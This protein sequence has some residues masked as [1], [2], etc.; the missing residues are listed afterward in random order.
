M[1][2]NLFSRLQE[3]KTEAE[4]IWVITESFLNKLSP[5]LLS[6]AWAAVIP[7]WFNPE[8]LA[9]LRPELQS[10]IAEL[11]SELLNLPFIEVFPKRGYDI[12]EVTRKVMLE[13]LWREYQDEFYILSARAA[14]YFSNGDKP[15]IQI[16]WLYHL[17]VVDANS[18]HYELFNL[19]RFWTNNF[20]HSELESLIGKL[21]EQVESNR[22]DMSAMADIYYWAG[23]VKLLFDK[24]TE[25]LQHYEQALEFY[26]NIGNDIY[27]A[28]T[29]TAIGDVLFHLKRREEAMQYYEQA[30]G[31]FRETN[32]AYG[33]AYILKA[34]GD[35]LKLE[36]DRREEALQNYEQA[37]AIYREISYY[38]GEAYILKAIG[39][40]LKLL[41]GRQEEALERYEQALVVYREIGNREYEATTLKAIGDVL[42]DVKRIDEAV[43]NYEQAL[44]LF[45][46]IGDDYQEAETFR[47]IA[48]SYSLQNTG[49][50]LRA[51]EYYHSAI[52]LYRSIGSRK[53][54]AITLLPLSLLYLELGKLRE[55]IRICCQ[56]YTILKDPE[57][58]EEM[59]FPQWSKSLIKFSQQ[60]RIQLALYLL[61]NVVLFPFVVILL[62][63]MKFTR[64]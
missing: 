54:E 46:D 23:K 30:F 48:I 10:Q 43:Q 59:P 51:L 26:R 25:A 41:D 33:E 56:H 62:F 5:E 20:R 9:A 45:H 19:A 1:K 21:L 53:D 29:L 8:V 39:N 24:E 49:D 22:V 16:E 35:L 27:A 60:G 7:H 58:L 63:L 42:L 57:I 12:H 2:E 34:I 40:L 61:L 50:K 28:K 32:D 55:Y 14:E 18:H 44:G 38:D 37:L 4:Q 31:L 47:A 13:Y 6:V 64:W 17:A 36:F 15:E 52:R 11:Y 3:A